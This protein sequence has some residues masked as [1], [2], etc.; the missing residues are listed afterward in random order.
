MNELIQVVRDWFPLFLAG[1]NV[2]LFCVVKFNDMSHL[3]K[4]VDELKRLLEKYCD[5]EKEI[6]ERLSKIEGTCKANHGIQ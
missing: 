2:A 5:K 4:T 6:A 3:G 1:G